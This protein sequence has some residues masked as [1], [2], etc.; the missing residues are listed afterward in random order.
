MKKIFLFFIFF[1]NFYYIKAYENDFFNI[2]IPDDYKLVTTEN[3]IY[4][5]EN[6]NKYISITIANN[7][8][9]YTIK[10]YSENDIEN[11]K[12]YIEDKINSSLTE[13]DTKVS[14]TD[15][16]KITINNHLS[17]SYTIYW[18]TVNQTGY[19]IYQF[20]NV[21]ATDNYM[22]TIVYN[23]NTNVKDEEFNSII[24]TFVP[25]DNVS[26]KH[27]TNFLVF[28]ITL[29]AFFFAIIHTFKKHKKRTK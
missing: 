1:F 16:Q 27:D 10:N 9:G 8:N 12:K 5:W 2:N 4:K 26:F 20:G 6:D 15:M 21:I 14:V 29:I 24:N 7:A 13:Y 3:N 22:Y 23:T 11:Q 25:K 17:L 28:I 18:P 19:D